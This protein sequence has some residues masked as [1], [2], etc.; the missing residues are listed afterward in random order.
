[1]KKEANDANDAKVKVLSKDRISTWQF[2]ISLFAFSCN[3]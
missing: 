3:F 1:M 2:S